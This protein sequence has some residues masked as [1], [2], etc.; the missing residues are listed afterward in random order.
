[1]RYFFLET[2]P[3]GPAKKK[4]CVRYSGT[5]SR[6]NAIKYRPSV[7]DGQRRRL[8]QKSAAGRAANKNKNG[9]NSKRH[10]GPPL[11]GRD[12]TVATVSR[13]NRTGH[14]RENKRRTHTHTHARAHDNDGRRETTTLDDG[15]TTIAPNKNTVATRA[16]HSV[17]PPLQDV[18]RVIGGGGRL[19]RLRFRPHERSARVDR[20]HAK[21]SVITSYQRGG[22]RRR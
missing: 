17:A 16:T 15:R 21:R 8:P 13:R 3:N 4:S 12:K 6:W 10:V 20:V 22:Y 1:M 5:V 7:S 2:R 18:W 9:R 11:R 14:G 19:S